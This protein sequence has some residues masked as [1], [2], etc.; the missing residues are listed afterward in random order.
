MLQALIAGLLVLPIVLPSPA[1]TG[2]RRALR[3]PVAVYLGVVSFGL[4]L[5]HIPVLALFRPIVRDP[6]LPVAVLGALGALTLAT[7]LAAASYHLV[8]RPVLDRVVRR[9][10]GWHRTADRSVS[11]PG[12]EDR[13]VSLMTGSPRVP[14]DAPPR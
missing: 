5:W 3:S 2:F 12:R 10:R 6:S 8:E 13:S 7:A 1:A 9:T 4:Y 11:R 14:R